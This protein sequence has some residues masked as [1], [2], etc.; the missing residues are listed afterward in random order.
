MFWTVNDWLLVSEN[1]LQDTFFIQRRKRKRPQKPKAPAF[2]Q[3]TSC[4]FTCHNKLKFQAH[5]KSH[6][7]PITCK[8]CGKYAPDR[9]KLERHMLVHTQVKNFMCTYCDKTFTHDCNR[10]TH[11]RIHTG[12]KPY[13]CSFCSF[14][15]A[16]VANMRHHMKTKHKFAYPELMSMKPEEEKLVCDVCNKVLDCK[17]TFKMH[18][19]QHPP[20][21]YNRCPICKVGF[22]MKYKLEKH[23]A[24]HYR[25]NAPAHGVKIDPLDRTRLSR[26]FM[27]F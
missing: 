6:E 3:C 19:D 21:D 14:S 27:D 16:Q 12:E 13:S 20:S 24:L 9:S 8:I 5:Q 2:Y 10:K 25:P 15:A 11:E 7:D 23:I 18:L 22:K 26:H 17:S 4:G 1:E